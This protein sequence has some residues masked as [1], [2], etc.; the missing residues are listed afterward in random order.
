M[1]I[2]IAIKKEQMITLI[3][4]IIKSYGGLHFIYMENGNG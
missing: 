2:A 4:E 1:T 3:N